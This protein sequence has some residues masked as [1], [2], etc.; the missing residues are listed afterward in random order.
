MCFHSQ[1]EYQ[2]VQKLPAT[3]C[4]NRWRA[5]H[6]VVECD[7]WSALEPGFSQEQ[8]FLNVVDRYNSK[9]FWAF[10]KSNFWNL[11][12]CGFDSENGAAHFS[13]Y[14][15]RNI[16]SMSGRFNSGHYLFYRRNS[17]QVLDLFCHQIVN[18][19]NPCFWMTEHKMSINF[20][21]SI[22]Q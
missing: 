14:C 7:P 9:C 4:K 18:T 10:P 17:C 12:P 16:S 20:W 6:V 15:S 8:I 5:I 13:G 2:W 3:N 22:L 11:P 21:V 19:P 1:R